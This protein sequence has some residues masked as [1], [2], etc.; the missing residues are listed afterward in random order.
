MT[1][2]PRLDHHQQPV[3]I[4]RP[5]TPTPPGTWPDP[6]ALATVIPDGPLPEQLNGVPFSPWSGAPA[7]NAGWQDLAEPCAFPEPP[8]EAKGMKA[9]AGAV[10][11]EPDGRVWVVAPSNAFGGYQAT[12]P[13][14]KADGMGLRATALKEVFEEAGLQVELVAHLVDVPRSTSRTRYYLARRKG[15]TPA[16]MGWESQAVHLAPP[17]SLKGLLHHPNDAPILE[18]LQKAHPLS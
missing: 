15:G 8:F 12:F 4:A 2:H 7:G 6:A 16:A 11:V 3:R 9:A 13:K 5:H 14:G 10:V 17:S 1:L 18:A